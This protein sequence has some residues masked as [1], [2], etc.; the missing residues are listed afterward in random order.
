MSEFQPGYNPEL[1]S[2]VEFDEAEAW[3]KLTNIVSDLFPDLPEETVTYLSGMGIDLSLTTN[4][5][6]QEIAERKE[7]H[8][9][10]FFE[11]LGEVETLAD[12][13]GYSEKLHQRLIDAG[14]LE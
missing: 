8:A 9:N 4:Q 3:E 7:T 1:E 5:E 6:G 14:I 12:E 11:A 10:D 13:Y 2:S